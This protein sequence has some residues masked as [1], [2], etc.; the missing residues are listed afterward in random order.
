VA[1][2]SE[3]KKEKNLEVS[4]AM[5]AIQLGCY[6]D[7]IRLY[8][9][10]NRYDL[11]NNLLQASG[12]Y[13]KAVKVAEKHDR[14]HLNSTH[15]QYA[16]H[17]ES[18]GDSTLAIEYYELSNTANIEVPRLLYQQGKIDQLE[19]YINSSKDPILWK[20]WACYLESNNR[21]EKA[22]KY[23]LK[24]GDYLSC[25]RIACHTVIL[26]LFKYV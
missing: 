7:A 5:L 2:L 4:V 22:Y 18:T 14:F 13:D 17:L 8:R 23:F 11:I 19:K 3:A 9:E 21:L 10:A 25:V 15:Y 24:A 6:D 12:K 16:K 20:W 26:I 1:A